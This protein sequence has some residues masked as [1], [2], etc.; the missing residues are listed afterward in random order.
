MRAIS[1]REKVFIVIG[2]AGIVIFAL[3]LL[4]RGGSLRPAAGRGDYGE[5]L[6]RAAQL[7]QELKPYPQRAADV[8]ALMEKF[9]MDP[10]KL[11]KASVV[12]QASAAIQNA[13]R[14]G[15]MQ[16]GPIRESPGRASARELATI[17]L[18]GTGQLPMALAFL[19][20]LETLGYPLLID[21]VQINADSKGPGMIKLS[22]TIIVLD[23]EQWKP[24]GAPHA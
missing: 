11:S 21:S 20:R 23:F 5:L 19:K 7:K 2:A 18:D 22:L 1:Q 13:A 14:S 4:S 9:Q 10:A 3:I 8:T 6:A 15:G 24:E 17:K 16:L 12:G